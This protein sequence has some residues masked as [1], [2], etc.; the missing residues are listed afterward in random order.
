MPCIW[1]EYDDSVVDRDE[2][3]ALC[4]ASKEA[5]VAVYGKDDVYAWGNSANVRT[6]VDPVEIFVQ[7]KADLVDDLDRW[8]SAV[9]DELRTWKAKSGFPHPINLTISPQH[10]KVALGI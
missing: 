8:S 9:S 6:E 2:A 10:W 4:R 7:L 1:I 5:I 3:A